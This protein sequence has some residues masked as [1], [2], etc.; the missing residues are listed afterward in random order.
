M[1]TGA[2]LPS[3]QDAIAPGFAFRAS[4]LP[5]AG[6]LGGASVA[7]AVALRWAAPDR[8]AERFELA[9]LGVGGEDLVRLGPFDE[10]DVIAEWR[11]LGAASG[12]PLVVVGEAGEIAAPYPQ[13]GPL[14]LGAVRLRRR[15]NLL[16]GRRPRF[17]SRRKVGRLPVRPLIHRGEPELA[18][19]PA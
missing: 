17:L 7:V 19:R 9:V 10:E 18:S 11:R 8:E 4:R 12:L 16:N 6:R 13:I 15:H 1:S 5:V 3:A 2:I 14:K